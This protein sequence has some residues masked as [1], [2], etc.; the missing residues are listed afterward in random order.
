MDVSKTPA[1]RACDEGP[2]EWQERTWLDEANRLYCRDKPSLA[3]DRFDHADW[4][5]NGANYSP[6]GYVTIVLFDEQ[7]A[8]EEYD[9]VACEWC[10]DPWCEGGCDDDDE[11][12]YW[13]ED[14]DDDYDR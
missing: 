6:A 3:E 4:V 5:R 14:D 11:D 8:D 7:H 2:V 13:D 10:D 12:D 1:T 9:I